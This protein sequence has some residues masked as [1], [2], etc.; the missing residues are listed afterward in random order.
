[1]V[2]EY[3][4]EKGTIKNSSQANELAKIMVEAAIDKFKNPKQKKTPY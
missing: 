3:K 2:N 4:K 1:M